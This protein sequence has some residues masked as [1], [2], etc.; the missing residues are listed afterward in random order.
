VKWSVRAPHPGYEPSKYVDLLLDLGR[1]TGS[2]LLVPTT[3]ETVTAVACAKEVLESRYAVACAPWAVAE[4]FLDKHLTYELADRLGIAMP[5]TVLPRSA[6]ELERL[7]VELPYPSLLK[8]RSSYQYREMFGA[9]MTVVH[10][11]AE[12]IS[13]WERAERGGVGTLVQEFIP[14]G[15]S[16]GVN[17]NAY[18]VDGEPVVE[19]TARKVRLSPPNIGYPTVVVSAHVP[20]VITPGRRLLKG[21]G[22]SGFANVE[23]KRDARDGSFCLMEVNGRPNMSGLLSMRC[24][25]DFPLMTYRH[26]VFGE[27]PSH[28][29][30]EQYDE[31]VY[32]ISEALDLGAAA[33]RIRGGRSPFR[34]LVEPY[35]RPHVF[36]E[37]SLTDPAPFGFRV[38]TKLHSALV[39]EVTRREPRPPS[40]VGEDNTPNRSSLQP[41][42]TGG[43]GNR[44]G[45][46]TGPSQ[47]WDTSRRDGNR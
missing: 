27:L 37:M 5:G 28:G 4:R 26:L 29:S 12:L 34:R 45:S 9:K 8:P 30:A 17:Y 44:L 14:G 31:G 46:V 21:L 22:L 23:F 40:R 42:T 6:A 38:L 2:G 33:S 3:D 39:R 25:A 24:G 15:E 36:A 20:Q 7:A 11:P 10:D 18:L 1:G 35:V 19:V 13:Q 43:C 41:R 47:P 16:E 32:W